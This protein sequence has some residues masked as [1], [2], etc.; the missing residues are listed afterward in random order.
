ML[1]LVAINN[2]SD[3][4]N[5]RMNEFIES[6][7]QTHLLFIWAVALLILCKFNFGSTVLVKA[8]V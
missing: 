5:H 6:V 7:T 3:N 8:H 4:T 1:R 2:I